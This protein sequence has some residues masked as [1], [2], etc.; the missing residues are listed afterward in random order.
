MVFQDRVFEDHPD[1]QTSSP[2]SENT[3]GAG[4]RK[5]MATRTRESQ[6]EAIERTR[7]ARS[8]REV[9]ESAKDQQLDDFS[10][11]F[12]QRK[13]IMKSHLNYLPNN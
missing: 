10:N 9:Q 7:S 6:M 11:P 5:T 3:N 2:V 4:K 13:N 1:Y 12:K 8:A